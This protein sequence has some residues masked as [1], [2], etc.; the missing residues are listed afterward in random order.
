MSFALSGEQKLISESAARFAQTLRER[1]RDTE[2]QGLSGELVRTYRELGLLGLDWPE[3]DGGVQLGRLSKGIALEE[4]AFGDA[5]AALALDRVSWVCSPLLD[6]EGA[7][8]RVAAAIREGG[9]GFSPVAC[10]DTDERLALESGR[11]KGRLPYLPASRCDVLYVLKGRRLAAIRDG[12]SL[13]PTLPGALDA[14]G[15][16]SAEID[17]PV[18]WSL[19]FPRPV[20]LEL[21]GLWRFYLAS[22][23]LGV[24]RAATEYAQAYCLERVAFGKKVAHHQ[25]VAFALVDMSIAVEAAR[26][27]VRRAAAAADEGKPA[28][29]ELNAAFLQASECALM[30]TT[31]AVQFLAS[32]GYV[33]DHPVEKW[34]R[35]ARALTLLMGGSDGAQLDANEALRSSLE[36]A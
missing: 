18:L 17:G 7:A 5:A 25:A 13:A 14:L 3:K 32:A 10:V 23:L 34:M 15:A 12:V 31:G 26:L 1:Q 35:E 6:I 21:A 19:D 29:L 28:A 36:A 11:L 30:T 20:A 9:E 27:L 24:S 8:D 33:R 4:L 22:V 16:S 2:A